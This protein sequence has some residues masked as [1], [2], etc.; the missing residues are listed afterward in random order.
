MS[1]FYIF[2][3]LKYFTFKISLLPEVAEQ[4]ILI[5]AK[6][7]N[8]IWWIFSQH[9]KRNIRLVIFL[10]KKYNLTYL[11]NKILWKYR[12]SDIR[13]CIYNEKKLSFILSLM[14]FWKCVFKCCTQIHQIIFLGGLLLKLSAW[15]LLATN[16]SWQ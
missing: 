2:G 7:C 9:L 6:K 3:I 8:L 5:K 13:K 16:K 4:T 15:Q 10:I 1:C 14:I 12:V 11:H